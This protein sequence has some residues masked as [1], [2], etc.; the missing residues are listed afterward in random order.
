MQADISFPSLLSC[1]QFRLKQDSMSNSTDSDT[2]NSSDGTS[3]AGAGKTS[4]RRRFGKLLGLLDRS[5]MELLSVNP[6]EKKDR[7]VQVGEAEVSEGLG[8][9]EGGNCSRL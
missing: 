4:V 5:L 8:C 1:T 3:L 7:L 2:A 9:P 6:K